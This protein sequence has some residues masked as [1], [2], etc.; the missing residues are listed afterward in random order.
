LCENRRGIRSFEI[1]KLPIMKVIATKKLIMLM[2][3]E[4]DQL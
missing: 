2:S 4:V 1:A 3:I